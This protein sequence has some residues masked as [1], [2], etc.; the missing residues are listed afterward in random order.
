MNEKRGSMNWKKRGVVAL[1][2]VLI[3]LV[4]AV[5]GAIYLASNPSASQNSLTGAAVG[6][7]GVKVESVTTCNISVRESISNIGHDFYCTGTDGFS[8]DE[9]NIIFDCQDHIIQCSGGCSGRAGIKVS[10]KNNVTIRNCN[11][12][13]FADGIKVDTLSN[14]TQIVNNFLY[15]NS[16]GLDLNNATN[17]SVYNNIVFQ[18]SFCGVNISG[19]NNGLN[20]GTY[21]TIW[22]NKITNN[23]SA[24][25]NE[26]CEDSSSNNFWNY[27]RTCSDTLYPGNSST[28]G[29]LG[30]NTT[31]IIGS[32]CLGGNYWNSY[33]GRDTSGDGLGDTAIPYMGGNIFGTHTGDSY[34]L[35]AQCNETPCMICEDTIKAGVVIPSTSGEGLSMVCNGASLTCQGT[36]FRGAG[37][38]GALDRR[39]IEIMNVHDITIT[40]CELYNFTYGIFIQNAYNITLTNV[41]IHDNNKSG[42]YLGVL[43]SDVT[44]RNST[45]SN[46]NISSQEYGIYLQSAK[47]GGGNN[48]IISN[49]I[50]NQ[51]VA[52]IYLGDS[53]EGNTI[54]SNSIYSNYQGVLINNSNSNSLYNNNIYSNTFSGVQV[55]SSILS[56]L[57]SNS[58][59]YNFVFNNTKYG[60]HLADAHSSGSYGITGRIYNNSIG[61]FMNNSNVNVR[62]AEIYNNSA[63]NVM[64]NNSYDIPFDANSSGSIYGL[65]AYNSRRITIGSNDNIKIYNN[66][67]GIYFKNVTNSSSVPYATTV[68]V[69]NNTQN[70]VLTSG[71]TKNLFENILVYG[72]AYGF[73]LNGSNN[74][75]VRS[76]VV[77]NFS[78]YNFYLNNSVNNSIYNNYIGNTTGGINAYDNGTNFWNT[79][80][81]SGTNIL[82]GSYLG[83]N[84]WSG[85]AGSDADGDGLGDIAYNIT[86]G[87]NQDNLPL[88]QSNL[89]CGSIGNSITLSGNLSASGNCLNIIAAN[90]TINC[91]GYTLS[92]GGA[93][94]GI[95]ITGY[96][97]TKLLNCKIQHFATGILLSG[98]GSA[99][100]TNNTI[101][102]NS[103]GILSNSSGLG[104]VRQNIFQNNN[105]SILIQNS[106]SGNLSYNTL[107]SSRDYSF[108]INQVNLSYFKYN[109]FQDSGAAVGAY[110]AQSY[111]NTLFANQ[112][113]S[114]RIGMNLSSSNNN[115]IYNNLFDNT[116]NIY[117]DGN[118][119]YNTSYN[120]TSGTNVLGG[121]CLGGNFWHN[122][123]GLDNGTGAYPHNISGDGI[124]D[125]LLP[126]NESNH[127]N[128][129]T[130]GD[131]LPLIINCGNVTT[132]L[133]LARNLTSNGTCFTV[134]SNSLSINCGGNALFGSGSGAAFQLSGRQNVKIY[135]CT[136]INFTYGVYASSSNNLTVNRT[137]VYGSTY[138]TYFTQ[139]TNS[140]FQYDTFYN[141]T[142]GLFLIN[143][144]NSNLIQNS[145]IYNNSYGIYLEGSSNWNNLTNSHL[146]SQFN[147]GAYFN[148]SSN[149][150]IYNNEFNNTNNAYSGASSSNIWN[151]SYSCSAVTNIVGGNCTGG[152]FW[153]D[154]TG[155]DSGLNAYPYNDSDDGIGDTQIPYNRN[156]STG[157]D[158]LPLTSTNGTITSVCPVTISKDVKLN[159]NL[160]CSSGG[161][162]IVI[163]TDDVTLDCQN[164]L[165][166]GAGTDSG[167]YLSGR[168]NIVI[169]NCNITRFY[170]GI[171]I[172]NSQNIQINS[173]NYIYNNDFYAIYQFSSKRTSI[174]GNNIVNDNNGIYSINSSNTTVLNNTINLQKKFYG[175]YGYNS[176][177]FVVVNN[178]LWNNYH[179]MY[180]VN[181]SNVNLTG[182][183]VSSSDVYS[184]FMNKETS[185]G[186]INNNIL[187][188]GLEAIRIKDNSNANTFRNNTIQDHL[189][190]GVYA[191]SS[192]Y[193]NFTNNTIR[194]NTF[195]VYLSGASG[196]S[197]INNTI[198]DS[199]PG[200]AA[201]G[202]SNN[203][204]LRNNTINSSSSPCVQINSSSGSSLIGNILNNDVNINQGSS[205]VVEN[206]TIR[207]NLLILSSD[208]SRVHNNLFGANFDSSGSDN[209]IFTSNNLTAATVNS[210]SG[211]QLSSNILKTLTVN[212]FSSGRISSNDVDDINGI[213]FNF[214]AITSSNISSNNI[215]NATTAI[216]LS[217]SSNSN[218]IYDNWLISNGVG[219][220][221]SSGTGNILYNNYL[222][223]TRNA[224]DI[225]GN[226][227][228]TSYSCGTP[229]IVGGPCKGGNFYS[230]YYGL[231]NGANSQEQGDGIG[232]QPNNYTIN[233]VSSID[234]LPLVLYIA[235]QYFKPT[236]GTAANL[237]AY[238]NISGLLSD[239][240]VVSNRVQIIN[241]TSGDKVYVEITGLFNQSNVN[242]ANL[243]IN[244]T[245]SSGTKTSLNKSGVSNL[246]STYTL[247]VY[248]NYGLDKGVYLCPGTYDLT[249]ANSTCNGRVNLTSI[250]NFSGYIL[251]SIGAYYKIS[252][253]TNDSLAVVL[254]SGDLC[255][256]NVMY[257]YIFNSSINCNTSDAALNVMAD[258]ITIDFNG[259]TLSG[260]GSGIGLNVV[261]RTNVII[262]GASI[263]GFGKGIFVDPSYSINITNSNISNNTVGIQF[264]L[265]NN[266]LIISNRIINNT[267][268][269]NL[270]SSYNNS[271]YNNYFNNT[272]NVRDDGNNT[273]NIS[274]STA[275]NILGLGA[276][277]GNFWSDYNGWD[278]VYDGFGDTAYYNITN[279][280]G[281]LIGIDYLPLT[282]FGK[283]T[284]GNVSW[285]ITLTRNV[286]ASGRC[287]EFNGNNLDFNCAGYTIMGNSTGAGIFAQ[288]KVNLTIRNC[289]IYNFSQG[290]WLNDTNTSNLSS[291][292]LYNNSYGLLLNGSSKNIIQNNDV[293]S[294]SVVGIKLENSSI[295][296]LT[297]NRLY[298][299]SSLTGLYLL[300]SDNNT[301]TWN[302]FTTL[303]L[304]ANL[305]SSNNNT[306]YNNIFN[307]TNN[308]IDTGRNY[309]NISYN[310]TAG[311]NAIGGNCTGGNYWSNYVGVDNVSGSGAYNATPWNITGDGIGNTLI[312]YNNS[313]NITTGG[314]YLPLSGSVN[315][316]TCTPSY[317]NCSA[318]S[319]CSGSTKTR[320]CYDIVCNVSAYNTESSSEGCGGGSTSSS[321]G[322][323]GGGGSST[324]A[325]TNATK[326]ECTQSWQC[327]PWGNCINSKQTRSCYDA[328]DCNYKKSLGSVNTVNTRTAPAQ[329]KTCTGEVEMETPL[330]SF[331]PSYEE[332][333]PTPSAPEPSP[334]R[335]ITISSLT[336]LAA[337]GGI[338]TYWYFAA[339]A[340]RLRRKLKKA[341]SL[342]GEAS[343]EL[344]KEHYMGSYN[345]YLKLSEGKK[346]NFYSQVTQLRE[347]IEEQL[348]GEKKMEELLL[349]SSQVNFN[350]QK[351]IYMDMY[352]TYLKLP[353]QVQ[354]KYYSGLVQLREQLERGGGRG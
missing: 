23:G 210:T 222:E 152:N 25:S 124:G 39:G 43:T 231:D 204:L 146:Y 135:N 245:E 266:S 330:T 181:S 225:G 3:A 268:G 248:H 141:N 2:G 34:P 340:N 26:A 52:G 239:G 349:R 229:N 325:V 120:C 326:I 334:I 261:N 352:N 277:G 90:L 341:Q 346:R 234:R 24:V 38:N 10:G 46:E 221:I 88:I 128:T 107:Q 177:G 21:N 291:N 28:Y 259:Y 167:I 87:S 184:L 138:G 7:E 165:L 65:Y 203:L 200:I 269:I 18:N 353:P 166:S 116:N 53:S 134:Q 315:I 299:M 37:P 180:F 249:N 288:S 112:I 333:E 276:Y 307:A 324:A 281:G 347:Q 6:L 197:L 323:G 305:S 217:S 100:L 86:G 241:Y 233:G 157:G 129:T 57:G 106:S 317:T 83:G 171:N 97:N 122:Y 105:Y 264:A 331:I 40:G 228:N 220:N 285:N 313:N 59:N 345:L 74:N 19:M 297:R 292:T 17:S 131:Y 252:N 272:N 223:N 189:S 11:I 114:N 98:A 190:Y 312:P 56:D 280:S 64:L 332:K 139:T 199:A 68:T 328:N 127:I 126:F 201:V 62:G 265:V 290:I 255:G 117:D 32:S 58:S 162:A 187:S 327:G 111:N 278:T 293:Y 214:S 33:T 118:N 77:S 309:W 271:I 45:I 151:I 191:S 137:A 311:L 49:T 113:Q 160:N 243:K 274:S 183:S 82:G 237:T 78:S 31:N 8:I 12:S 310:C 318:W 279:S 316:S 63:A 30:Y 224:G 319:A 85:Y 286:S 270:S 4:L 75:T 70:I 308:V 155:T 238:G 149:N 168:S 159:Q 14:R 158:Y 148:S 335:E 104:Q 193:N 133:N 195:N 205:A 91:G 66:T 202:S 289:R 125:T 302:N 314:D 172:V 298:S 163:A 89:S 188:S 71:S 211:S 198:N 142:Y 93:G 81:S 145:S 262:K 115:L 263:R 296:N 29:Q 174:I 336:A 130:Y 84:F 250:G 94:V 246:D 123:Q 108:Y 351:K 150:S 247:Y 36:I 244:F 240:V 51:T 194:N 301:F 185:S 284:C 54:T 179:G 235:R 92:G 321:G 300:N 354:Q 342:T 102:N 339:P 69:H 144:S 96:S 27:N 35:V 175:I 208:D 338:Y 143:S 322:G 72:G 73:Y 216:K 329:I 209:L 132:N 76:S 110:L 156:I 80:K 206:N 15:N 154:Y 273:W 212:N 232:D 173:S 5:S 344:L 295:N 178:T 304:G 169:K 253:I 294:E 22:N 161:N 101:I 99:N 170:Y 176:P 50:R 192:S 227:W 119:T 236:S 219:M 267:L 303:G 196:F 306:F 242:A 121:S 136:L 95:N 164:Y 153:S 226:Y 61:L 215:K 9:N 260:N 47:V 55:I 13:N 213:S 42:I 283:I 275:T 254:N 60:Y 343:S 147:W 218:R 230:D 103:W 348:K 109:I 16:D 257:N 186:I 207:N 258:N 67:Y 287:F 44:I 20:S 182:N 256:A 1:I 337:F 140:T 251:S 48:F 320:N 350:D 41:T 282:E 79:S